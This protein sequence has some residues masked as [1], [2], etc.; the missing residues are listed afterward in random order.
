MKVGDKVWVK[1]TISALD[2]EG[3]RLITE[4]YGQ[5][6]WAANKEFRL[7]SEVLDANEPVSNHCQGFVCN[8]AQ[9]TSVTCPHDSCDIETGVRNPVIKQSLTTASLYK[10]KDRVI[11]VKADSLLYSHR[12]TITRIDF[13]NPEAP[14]Y[15]FSSDSGSQFGWFGEKDIEHTNPELRGVHVTLKVGDKVELKCNNHFDGAKGLIT[16]RH[17]DGD[18]FWFEALDPRHKSISGW[19][20]ETWE[21]EEY[22]T[23]RLIKAD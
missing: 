17:A 4:V 8:L 14:Y 16:Q 13:R 11:I 6:F 2:N 22:G 1:A 7:E 12:G 23:C 19:K 5:R 18:L 20:A 21:S 10:V 3:A 9:S 15:F